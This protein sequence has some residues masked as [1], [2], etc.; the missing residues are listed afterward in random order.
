LLQRSRLCV[1]CSR[2]LIWQGLLGTKEA[3]D[4]ATRAAAQ[5]TSFHNIF[6][7]AGAE[8][9]DNGAMITYVLPLA[10][11]GAVPDANRELLV[12]ALVARINARNG[13]WSGGIINN[14]FLFDV[15]H[16][17]GHAD[18]ALAMLKRKDYPSYGYMYFNV[19][20]PAKECM[21]ELPD[22]PFEGTGMNS[23]NHHMYSSVGHYLI[24]RV[25]GLSL[26]SVHGE[27]VAIAG[28]EGKASVKLRL[29]EG[30][31]Q[32]AWA[33]EGSS[34]EVQVEI[35]IPIGLKAQL[36]LPLI[37]GRLAVDGVVAKTVAVV[38]QNG[39]K[40]NKLILAAGKYQIT[41]IQTRAHESDNVYVV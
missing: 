29:P 24:T 17:N 9:Y 38:H 30:D 33:Y 31:A 39:S 27:L 19:L 8:H 14:R 23:R 5:A 28:R 40:Y 36:H 3:S 13:T 18:L 26:D 6:W 25:G 11:P 1:P 35:T 4:W 2:Q 15:L 22:A 16:E 7:D 12:N 32:F 21:W 34:H 37:A 41:T 20:E 10:L